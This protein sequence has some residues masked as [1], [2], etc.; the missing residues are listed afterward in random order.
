[1]ER[2]YSKTAHAI[3]KCIGG[4]KNVESLTHCMT[5]LRFRLKDETKI[6]DQKI[7][8]I[9]GVTG[10]VRQNGQYQIIIGNDVGKCYGEL[11]KLGSFKE[12]SENNKKKKEIHL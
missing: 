11:L 3:L 1:M 12:E 10:V 6:D 7:K 2:D 4:D 8:A 5:R 9:S